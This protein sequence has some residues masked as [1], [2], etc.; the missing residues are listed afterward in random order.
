MVYSPSTT[1][2]VRNDAPSMAVRMFG[3]TTDTIDF[4]SFAA[5]TCSSFAVQIPADAAS[6]DIVFMVPDGGEIGDSSSPLTIE[7]GVA[8]PGGGYGTIHICNM[9]NSAFDP[10]SETFQVFTIRQ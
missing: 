5:H 3:T 8:S 7:T 6:T 1:A 4:V 10:P 9:S 2:M